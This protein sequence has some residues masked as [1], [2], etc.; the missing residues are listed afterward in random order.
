V[1]S[2]ESRSTAASTSASPTSRGARGGGPSSR[3]AAPAAGSH[4]ATST[5]SAAS[6][7]CAPPARDSS[8]AA[9]ASTTTGARERSGSGDDIGVLVLRT[10]RPATATRFNVQE[11]RPRARGNERM[12]TACPDGRGQVHPACRARAGRVPASA[13]R[14][15]VGLPL[16]PSLPPGA[17][18]ALDRAGARDPQ[19]DD[20]RAQCV[21]K[22]S[23]GGEPV[24][25]WPNRL[26]Q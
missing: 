21:G 26:E 8:S 10:V 22:V 6:S 13:P 20:E 9:A 17:G 14:A 23:P 5:T 19:Y 3:T 11:A 18:R 4:A 1:R 2:P 25:A 15:S 7:R 24:A 16:A 12:D